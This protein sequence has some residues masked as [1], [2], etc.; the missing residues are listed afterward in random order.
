MSSTILALLLAVALF[1]GMLVLLEVG[2]RWRARGGEK[3]S[4]QEQSGLGVVEGA[5]FGLFGLLIAFTFSGA[6]SRF[7]AHRQLI[8]SETNAIGTAY[9]RLDL[10]P[11][12]AQP[13]LRDLFRQ[14]LDSRIAVYRK[15]P[16]IEAAKV[17][18][19]RCTKLQGEIWTD[20]VAASQLPGAQPDA[21]KLLLPALNE[22]IDITT[23]REMAADMHPPIIIFVLLIAL[24]LGCS[25]LAGYRIFGSRRRWLHIIVFAAVVVIT[26]YV[27]LDIEYPRR[28]LI[29]LDRYDRVLVGLRESMK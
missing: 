24:A 21:A 26:I 8:A 2:R 4:E 25:L 1:I 14:Y 7:D 9:L 20:A 10:L 12:D 23:T 16:N 28:G 27:I 18:L 15:L 3:E 5:V 17:E 13:A 6:V 19:A 11:K 22:M 29:R